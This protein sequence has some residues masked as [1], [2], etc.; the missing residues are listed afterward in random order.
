MI[1]QLVEHSSGRNISS[2]LIYQTTALSLQWFRI[3]VRSIF[4]TPQGFG[5]TKLCGLFIKHIKL[6]I[7]VFLGN[8]SIKK[9]KGCGLHNCFRF[10]E[11]ASS[12]QWLD[13]RLQTSKPLVNNRSLPL[14]CLWHSLFG[15]P[16]LSLGPGCQRLFLRCFRFR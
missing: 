16:W 15:S 4:S 10:K 14:G 9:E 6:H 11:I 8:I 5:A 3:K 1:A 13:K 12:P 2:E 7:Y